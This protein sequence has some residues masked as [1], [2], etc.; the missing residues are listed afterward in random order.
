MLRAGKQKAA[1]L[2]KRWKPLLTPN[3][4]SRCQSGLWMLVNEAT[5]QPWPVR[6]AFFRGPD[7]ELIELSE[8]KTGYT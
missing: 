6:V 5:Q 3:S 1:M 7:G 8:Y 2:V 4:R